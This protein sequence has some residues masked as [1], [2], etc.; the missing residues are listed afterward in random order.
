M[1]LITQQLPQYC[2]QKTSKIFRINDAIVV[3]KGGLRTTTSGGNLAVIVM[4]D[5]V[6]AALGGDSQLAFA[7]ILSYIRDHHI[8]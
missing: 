1:K 3:K 2:D 4:P 5:K 7:I 8:K 6:I